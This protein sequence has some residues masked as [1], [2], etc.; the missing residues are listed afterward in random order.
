MLLMTLAEP[1]LTLPYGQCGYCGVVRAGPGTGERIRWACTCGGGQSHLMRL[2]LRLGSRVR[3][4]VK[5]RVRVRVR[6][7]VQVQG[8]VQVGGGPSNVMRSCANLL[9]PPIHICE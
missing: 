6:V 4:R 5:V 2:G 9:N 8:Q 7:Q 3:V 1:S